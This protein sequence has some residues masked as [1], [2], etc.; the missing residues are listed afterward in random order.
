MKICTRVC[1]HIY[2]GWS[3]LIVSSF[4]IARFSH[5]WDSPDNANNQKRGTR[6]NMCGPGNVWFNLAFIYLFRHTKKW[7]GLEKINQVWVFLVST[8]VSF[9]LCVELLLLPLTF[10]GILSADNTELLSEVFGGLERGDKGMHI[11]WLASLEI[12]LGETAVGELGITQNFCIS[13]QWMCDLAA[14]EMVALKG[15][16]SASTAILLRSSKLLWC[17]KTGN[18]TAIRPSQ[19]AISLWLK[20]IKQMNGLNCDKLADWQK[21]DIK[22]KFTSTT[23]IPVRTS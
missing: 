4:P 12:L 11:C 18:K 19:S 23:Y 5:R 16:R 7:E 2:T 13:V 9:Q 1:K 14:F 8:V 6:C 21:T 3:Y 15:I 20:D 17:I 10:M 22:S